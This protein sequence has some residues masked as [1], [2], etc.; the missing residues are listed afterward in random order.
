MYLKDNKINGLKNHFLN[1][2]S[3]IY[4]KREAENI[5]YILC[6]DF[7]SIKRNEYLLNKDQRLSE[8]DILRFHYA[9]KDLKNNKPIQ[10]I[11]GKT[12]FYGHRLFVNEHVLIPR[13]ETEELVYYVLQKNKNSKKNVLDIATGSGCIACTL[14]KENHLFN[15]FASDISENALVVANKNAT[16]LNTEITF[17]KDDVLNYNIH[18]YPPQID[19]I[20]SNPP[21]VTQKEKKDMRKNVLDYEPHLALFVSN[22]NPLYFYDKICDL[23]NHILTLNGEL[24]FEVHEKYAGDIALLMTK[25]SFKNIEIIK[26]LNQKPRIVFG[27]KV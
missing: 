6:E 22:D 21:Y 18:S 5:F 1:E 7:L 11:T 16:S 2:L 8:S 19:I 10:Y 9:L 24:W 27:K 26:D 12:I 17:I 15:V 25:N 23:A 4:E 14:K 13:P 3:S 20:V